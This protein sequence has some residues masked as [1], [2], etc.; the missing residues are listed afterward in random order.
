[1]K[2]D[3]LRFITILGWL[4]TTMTVVMYSSYMDQIHLNL[5]GAKGSIILPIST[6]F[7]CTL[8]AS[9]GFL[10]KPRNWP[11]IVANIP[12]ILLGLVTL[13]TAL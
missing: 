10:K 1:M 6:V 2:T 4:A 9:Y 3:R 11:I 13:I 5:N 8:W 12:G 7:N